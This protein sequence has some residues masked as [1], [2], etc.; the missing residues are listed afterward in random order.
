MGNLSSSNLDR[1]MLLLVSDSGMGKTG[2]L[3]SL[4]KAGFSLRILDFDN[5]TAIVRNL[6]KDDPEALD[7][8]YVEKCLDS[9]KNVQGRILPKTL[10]AWPKCAKLLSDWKVGKEGEE[11]Y[12]NLGPVTS[13][14]NKDILVLDSLTHAGESAMRYHQSL[15]AKT[16]NHPTLP[17]WGIVQTMIK[18]LLEMLKDSEVKCHVIVITHID[19]RYKEIRG[20][21]DNSM[22]IGRELE[23]GYPSAPGNK[24]PEKVGSYFNDAL[25]VVTTGSGTAKRHKITT[26]PM[27][28]LGLKS[29]NPGVAKR[30]YPIETGLADYFKDMLG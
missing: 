12:Y 8:V 14:T 11:G 3:A 18:D 30:D 15:N 22:V 5:G 1:L 9:F 4:A 16:G 13:W 21:K 28:S 25:Q 27:V 26:V 6:L 17:D 2:S 29:S 7:R 23:G 19:W 10:T 20:G 24:L